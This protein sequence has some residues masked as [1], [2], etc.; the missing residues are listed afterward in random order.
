MNHRR[1]LWLS[2]FCL[3]G[4]LAGLLWAVFRPPVYQ[5]RA[6]LCIRQAD[7]LAALP[8]L[9]D[10]EITVIPGTF[11]A[12]I[13]VSDSTAEAAAGQLDRTLQSVPTFLARL[14]LPA[15]PETVC[16]T[17][18][19][20]PEK[21]PLSAGF[22]GFALVLALG[23]ILLLPAPKSSIPISLSK[24]L[25]RTLLCLKKRWWA[26]LTVF[27]LFSGGAFLAE[28]GKSPVFQSTALVRVG[29]Y[30]PDTAAM[31]SAAVRGLLDSD[32]APEAIRISSL[33]NTNLFRLT[34]EGASQA[35]AQSRLTLL[36]SDWPR[37]DNYS[38]IPL[39]LAVLESPE[40][41]SA[42]GF[43]PAVPIKWGLIGLV[44]AFGFTFVFSAEKEKSFTERP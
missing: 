27:L 34:A 8:G 40:P 16:A 43:S 44:L 17:T 14:E 41:A 23:L 13:A 32:L 5:A 38:R 31:V 42:A 35:E 36:L 6:T 15:E 12:E 18:R 30:Q 2:L 9:P 29:R 20:L 19:L 22:A 37:L 39:D 1:W 25:V 33:G 11:L 3:G 10:G 26:I 28:A 7:A 4:F 21:S 24:T